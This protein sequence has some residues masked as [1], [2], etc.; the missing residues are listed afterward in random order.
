[1]PAMNMLCDFG[2]F[3]AVPLTGTIAIHDLAAAVKLDA[4]ILS[5]AIFQCRG[6]LDADCYSG[7]FLRIALTQGIFDETEL[8][9]YAHTESS[10][11]FR[12][13]QAASFYRLG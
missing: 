3:D 11:I 13:D 2:V 7:R 12:T 1:M 10:A 5:T 8:D 4:A 9:L 6:S